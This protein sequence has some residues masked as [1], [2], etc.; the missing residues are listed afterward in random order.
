MINKIH[1]YEVCTHAYRENGYHERNFFPRI[2][3]NYVL[4]HPY[5]ANSIFNLTLDK[6][7]TTESQNL[8]YG[9]VN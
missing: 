4:E 6:R 2:F 1:H 3:S 8:G 9:T 5:H 7:K